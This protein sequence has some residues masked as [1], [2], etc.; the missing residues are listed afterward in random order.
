MITYQEEEAE[1]FKADVEPLLSRY[2]DETI[3]DIGLQF[4]ADFAVYIDANQRGRMICVS[5]REDGKVIGISCFFLT[6][7]LYSRGYMMAIQDLLYIVPEHRKGWV[8]IR[9][10]KES[11]KVLKSRG[12]GIIDLACRPHMDNTVLYERL[13][14]KYAEK[15]FSKLV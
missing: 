7:Y 9:L 4:D 6:P 14:Y 1:D 8:G 11:E 13:G 2:Y 15:R 5:A 3:V 10:I 12:V